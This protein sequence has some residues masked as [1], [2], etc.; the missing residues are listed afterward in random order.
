MGA[1]MKER[2]NDR[3]DHA[4][5]MRLTRLRKR[6]SVSGTPSMTESPFQITPEEVHQISPALFA[7]IGPR[8]APS[9]SKIKHLHLFMS[10]TLSSFDALRA[11]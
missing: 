8:L 2:E 7:I 9:Q 5:A 11:G 6:F 4:A 10:A 3:S 1:S